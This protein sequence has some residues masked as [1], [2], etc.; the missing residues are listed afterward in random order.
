[1][2][3]N[4]FQTIFSDLISKGF[5]VSN[6]LKWSFFFFSNKK[7]NLQQVINE[8]QGHNYNTIIKKFDNKEF[9]LI[10]DKTE[11]LT[12]EKLEKRNI[13]FVELADYCDVAYDGWEVSK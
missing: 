5:E 12:P 8:L 2:E 9:R 1:M 7:S 13:A 6:P 11:V 3:N 10:A 4:H